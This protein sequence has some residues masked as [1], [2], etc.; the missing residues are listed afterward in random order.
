[1]RPCCLGWDRSLDYLAKLGKPRTS[2]LGLSQTAGID[3]HWGQFPGFPGLPR[4]LEGL[5][6]G[7]C[8]RPL[9]PPFLPS[10]LRWKPLKSPLPTFHNS[11][12]LSFLRT[13]AP[14]THKRLEDP[15]HLAQTENGQPEP[16]AISPSPISREQIWGLW[17]MSCRAGGRL[18]SSG[19]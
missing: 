10:R 7:A 17:G 8:N 6:A 13:P 9:S 2:S 19:I 5:G 18:G 12:L 16:G 11:W 1:M 14:S 4:L 15:E 3:P